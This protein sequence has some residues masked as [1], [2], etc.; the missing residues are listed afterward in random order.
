MILKS[1]FYIEVQRV[2][3]Y[4]F[5]KKFSICRMFPLSLFVVTFPF[6]FLT[7]V[8]LLCHICYLKI[9]RTGLMH[10][11]DVL[12]LMFVFDLV[13]II[14][15]SHLEKQIY[16]RKKVIT[17]SS[18]FFL[19]PCVRTSM[20]IFFIKGSSVIS[21]VWDI[22]ICFHDTDGLAVLFF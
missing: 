1:F 19:I 10:L 17:S 13:H 5:W 16:L 21:W 4:V 14:C 2:P 8:F 7:T 22:C 3:I 15:S 11:L 6:I 12:A 9:G 18:C 20:Q